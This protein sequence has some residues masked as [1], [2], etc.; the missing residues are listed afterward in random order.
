[1]HHPIDIILR[2]NPRDCL[3]V[4]DIG[5]DKGIIGLVFQVLKVLQISGIGQQIHIDDTN[6]IPVLA[7]HIVNVI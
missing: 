2:K 7:K 5:L 6:L 3:L 1:M 4:A